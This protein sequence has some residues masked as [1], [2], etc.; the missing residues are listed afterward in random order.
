MKPIH[1]PR[2]E[3]QVL[4]SLEVDNDRGWN[5]RVKGDRGD[6]LVLILQRCRP[7]ALGAENLVSRAARIRIENVLG[8]RRKSGWSGME[9]SLMNP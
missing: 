7:E 4:G 6:R 5:S 9:A 1:K 8:E 3:I 2:E